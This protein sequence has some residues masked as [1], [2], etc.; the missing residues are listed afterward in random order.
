MVGESLKPPMESMVIL[1]MPEAPTASISAICSFDQASELLAPIPS[2]V[3]GYLVAEKALT[4]SSSSDAMVLNSIKAGFSMGSISDAEV[5]DGLGNR[6][7]RST[8]DLVGTS[9]T[10]AIVVQNRFSPL[11]DLGNGVEDEFMEGEDHV[12]DQG[13]HHHVDMMRQRIVG[14]VGEFRSISGLHLFPRESSEVFDH[15]CGSGEKDIC[16]LECDPLSRWE[17]NDLRE[18]VLV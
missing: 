1:V 12:E 6:D 15:S 17:P 13:S 10:A 11:S 7:S 9:A 16:V 2:R 18:L 8:G 4:S 3:L 14:S 5:T